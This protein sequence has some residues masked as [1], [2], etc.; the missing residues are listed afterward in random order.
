MAAAAARG[1]RVEGSTWLNRANNAEGTRGPTDTWKNTFKVRR[2]SNGALKILEDNQKK[3]VTSQE[4]EWLAFCLQASSEIAESLRF[5]TFQKK[6]GAKTW[7]GAECFWQ[8]EKTEKNPG[9]TFWFVEAT[10]SVYT[11][12]VKLLGRTWDSETALP[13]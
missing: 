3:I 6:G 12:T 4:T 1:W 8:T 13:L 7:P 11:F 2:V 10:G 5:W 9:W